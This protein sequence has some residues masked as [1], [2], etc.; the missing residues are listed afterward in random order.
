MDPVTGG[1]GSI[2]VKTL[3]CHRLR[4]MLLQ[5]AKHLIDIMTHNA[6]TVESGWGE[7]YVLNMV[8]N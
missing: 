2:R 8:S 1:L 7:E 5:T 3:R 6:W 4:N